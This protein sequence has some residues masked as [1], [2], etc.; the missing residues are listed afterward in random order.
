MEFKT[1]AQFPYKWR[2]FLLFRVW[3]LTAPPV[4][5]VHFVLYGKCTRMYMYIYIQQRKPLNRGPTFNFGASR[6]FINT[7]LHITGHHVSG[8]HDVGVRWTQI[9]PHWFAGRRG[10]G[11]QDRGGQSNGGD[12]WRQN[13]ME[14]RMFS[15]LRYVVV[16]VVVVDHRRWNHK[17][18][19]SRTIALNVTFLWL[20]FKQMEAKL[21]HDATLERTLWHLYTPVWPA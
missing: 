3:Q 14:R 7:G 2:M 9:N 1:P 15:H 13:E 21:C 16:V 6:S 10:M 17:M 11:P 8:V 18:F 20:A 5:L 12:L 4:Y 19:Y